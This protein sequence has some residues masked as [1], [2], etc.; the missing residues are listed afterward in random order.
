M[1]RR[2]VSFLAFSNRGANH[3]QLTCSFSHKEI[4]EMQCDLLI[5]NLKNEKTIALVKENIRRISDGSSSHCAGALNLVLEKAVRSK[6]ET[7]GVKL[8]CSYPSCAWNTRPVP[9]SFVEGSIYYCHSGWCLQCVGCGTNRN[10]N[11]SSC[12]GCGIKFIK[13][14]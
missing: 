7:M 9:Y 4:M 11:Y 6:K 1:G 10:G 14:I 2:R 8:R 12:Q 5:S 3:R 13:F